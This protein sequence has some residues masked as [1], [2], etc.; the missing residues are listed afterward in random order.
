MNIKIDISPAMMS[1]T[2]YLEELVKELET[3]REND[4]KLIRDMGERLHSFVE[5]CRVCRETLKR[6]DSAIMNVS[7]M[8]PSLLSIANRERN[9]ILDM[10]NKIDKVMKP[11]TRDKNV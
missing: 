6:L 4:H 1:R 5:I 3:F 7:E 2:E 10:I 8:N 11:T 9:K